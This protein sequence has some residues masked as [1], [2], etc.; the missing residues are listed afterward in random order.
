ME[1]IVGHLYAVFDGTKPG[2]T[3]SW[4]CI[5]R[6]ELSMNIQSLLR[7][8]DEEHLGHLENKQIDT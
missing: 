1:A 8:M 3:L 4:K 5:V 2:L 6:S 7:L